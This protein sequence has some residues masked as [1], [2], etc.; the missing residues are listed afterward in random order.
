M[1]DA[2]GTVRG[3]ML[4]TASDS[5]SVVVEHKGQKVEVRAPTLAQQKKAIKAAT[6]KNGEIDNFEVAVLQII[7]C[8]YVAGTDER[9]FEIADK[10][11]LLNMPAGANSLVAKLANALKEIVG[12][13]ETEDIAKK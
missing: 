2:R 12:S 11:A 8:T 9:V 13:Q 4:G 1:S 3:V 10:E 6:D 7:A 5:E